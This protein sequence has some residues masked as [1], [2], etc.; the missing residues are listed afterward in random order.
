[1]APTDPAPTDPEQQRALAERYR[2]YG[3][4][5]AQHSGDGLA[6]VG[7]DSTAEDLERIRIA[8]GDD[9][10]TFIG[11]SAGTFLG[12]IYAD[13]YPGRVRG[14]VL[15]GAVDPSLRLDQRVSAQAAGFEA[16]LRSFLEWCAATSSCA[17][18]PMGD[19]KAAFLVLMDRI[20]NQPLAAPEGELVGVAK[21]L[22]GTLGRLT[23]RSRWASLGDALAA[24]EGGDGGPF[25]TLSSRYSNGGASNAAE[26]RSAITCLDHPSLRDLES[27]PALADAARIESPVFGPVFVWSTLSCGVWP[28][29]ASLAARP[30]RAAGAPPILVVGT[31][32]DPATPQAW[33]EALAAQLESGVL[34]LRQ[35]AEHVAYYYSSCV[36]AIVDDYLINGSAPASGTVCSR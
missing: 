7:T 16:S 9:R 13:R 22:N 18:R 1:A 6:L 14:L 25:A 26:A 19:L 20:R 30:V 12:A 17:W 4:A 33:A 5:C 35:G 8:L 28:H 32:G 2:A 29:Q 21:L 24:A 3:A 36:R 11:H 15:D 27:Y 10:L 31:T 23:S 34:V